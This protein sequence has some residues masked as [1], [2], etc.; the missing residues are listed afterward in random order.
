MFGPSKAR[1]DAAAAL[2][3]VRSE[4]LQEI[5]KWVLQRVR[6]PSL[7]RRSRHSHKR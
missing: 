4:Q 2:E 7:I 3:W 6:N 5:R 1:N